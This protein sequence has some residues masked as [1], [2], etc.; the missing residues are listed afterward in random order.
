MFPNLL[1]LFTLGIMWGSSFALARYAMMHGVLPIAYTFWHILGPVA[2]LLIINAK[3]FS[4]LSA[5]TVL[6]RHYKFFLVIAT[7]GIVIPDL[8]KFFLANHLSSGALGVIIN[9]IPF[10]IYPCALIAGE[11]RFRWSR[12]L[13]IM[14][15]LTGILLLVTDGQAIEIGTISENGNRH[16]WWTALALLSPFCYAIC[17]V[18]IVKRRPAECTPTMLSLGMLSVAMILLLPITLA[19]HASELLTTSL[20]EMQ[21][22]FHTVFTWQVIMVI[23]LE[24]TLTT[25][26][27]ILLF[28]LLYRAGSIY[29]SFTDGIVALTSLSWGALIFGEKITWYIAGGTT[30]IFLGI[31]I[32]VYKK[33]SV[34]IKLD[35]QI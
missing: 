8:N 26:G 24:I 28:E 2:V 12:W 35:K 23:A 20:T 17:S 29:Y 10:F 19:T 22:H 18:Y 15:G 9:T 4:A 25:I 32:E 27:Y 1:L 30:L 6:R 31:A 14:V 11:D 21:I 7:I 13:G 3:K 34:A 16:Y 33:H 5:L